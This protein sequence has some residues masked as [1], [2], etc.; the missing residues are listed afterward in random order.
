MLPVCFLI[1]FKGSPNSLWILKPICMKT[2]ETGICT[3][4]SCLPLFLP[5]HTRLTTDCIRKGICGDYQAT[6][7]SAKN[8]PT[9]P[10]W[11]PVWYIIYIWMHHKGNFSW[12]AICH[13]AGSWESRGRPAA[14]ER[15]GSSL[16]TA[17]R[18]SLKWEGQSRQ[19]HYDRVSGWT[20][21][22]TIAD[23]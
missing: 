13:P 11:A 8:K 6:L 21:L 10:R 19:I 1:T 22:V 14:E 3:R 9:N 2:W 4:T 16:W 5:L 17:R 20:V 7:R 18:I 15:V 12:D 23:I